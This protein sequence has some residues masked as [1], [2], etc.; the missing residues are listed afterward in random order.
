ML[1]VHV[2]DLPVL[3]SHELLAHDVGPA[4]ARHVT[5]GGDPLAGQ[6]VLIDD[7]AVVDH[8]TTTFEP[9]HVH[10]G[11]NTENDRRGA[12]AATVLEDD[13][14]LLAIVEHILDVLGSA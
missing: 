4:E 10:H 1:R 8:E 2:G 7:D 9:F 14:V 13:R 6:E 12:E 5:H 3:D 11:T